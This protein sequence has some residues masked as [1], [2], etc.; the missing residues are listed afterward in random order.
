MVT[1]GPLPGGDDIGRFLSLVEG[2][3]CGFRLSPATLLPMQGFNDD[4]TESR[5]AAGNKNAHGRARA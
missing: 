5:F 1:K 4:M 3:R 2:S